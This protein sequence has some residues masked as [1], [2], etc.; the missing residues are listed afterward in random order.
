MGK[1]TG[2]NRRKG[3]TRLQ[4][5]RRWPT[6]VAHLLPGES[7][8]RST[9]SGDYADAR[10]RFREIEEEYDRLVEDAR[11]RA[12][13]P[14]HGIYSRSMPQTTKRERE[15]FVQALTDADAYR[16]A[17]EYFRACVTDLDRQPP[18][19]DPDEVWHLLMELGSRGRALDD[20]KSPQGLSRASD[21]ADKLLDE[22]RLHSEPG[23]ASECL[24][25]ELV[26]QAMV[27][28]VALETAQLSGDQPSQIVDAFLNRLP[29]TERSRAVSSTGITLATL[30]EHFDREFIAGEDITTKTMNKNRAALAIIR[31]YFGD[32]TDVARIDREGLVGFRDTLASLPPNFTKKFGPD[33]DLKQI[34]TR[35]LE[36]E[37]AVLNRETQTTYL[38]LANSLFEFA[39]ERRHVAHND[40]AS[41][42]P[43][44]KA[45]PAQSRRRP[46]APAQLC[47]IFTAPIYTGCVD[48]ER[49]FAKSGPNHPRR[50]RFW[51][52]LIALFTG[53][54]MEEIL[55]LT[56]AHIKLGRDN[57]A[58]LLIA[59]GMKVKTENGFREVPLHRELLQIGFMLHVA[60]RRR[61][62]DACLL[63]D[64]VPPAS[65]GYRSTNFSKRFATFL[66]SLGI[67]DDPRRTC[68]HSYRHNFRDA[69]R[70]P[71]ANPD[72]VREAG[73]WASRDTS[74]IYGDGT[75]AHLMRGLI[76][77]IDYDLDLGHLYSAGTGVEAG[78]ALSR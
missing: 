19:S 56:P 61:H 67:K 54:R 44:G 21:V 62:G 31:R 77:G 7:M 69:L 37:G 72:F 9:G 49:G 15:R 13:I 8:A 51:V 57:L 64:D 74:D 24:L 33:A 1:T 34:A 36:A 45:T 50:S 17:R 46:F 14:S 60:E 3:S 73:G 42:R 18:P 12:A 66:K 26:R 70:Q 32:D 41:L 40:A 58:F 63:F 25:L 65:D 47:S 55:Q 4:F 39:K 30:I 75:P 11:L 38:R 6:D 22:A 68:F 76:D 2:L 29:V 59:P 5:R 43:K 78:G 35:N 48:D 16:V 23:S 53:L 71:E 20:P 28:L 52:P 10:R 27:Q